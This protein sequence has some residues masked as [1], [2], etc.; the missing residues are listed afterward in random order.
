MALELLLMLLLLIT[1]VLPPLLKGSSGGGLPI[2][3]ILMITAAAGCA[4]GAIIARDRSL[5]IEQMPSMR[6]VE[7]TE[8]G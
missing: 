4:V 1:A 2:G 3:R 6:P 7:V 8:G 5:T